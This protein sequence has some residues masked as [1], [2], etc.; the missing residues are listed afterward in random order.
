[1]KKAI[2][3]AKI[4]G[5]LKEADGGPSLLNCVASTGRRTTN[6]MRSSAA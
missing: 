4:I 3:E 1:M 5:V 6:G 2:A